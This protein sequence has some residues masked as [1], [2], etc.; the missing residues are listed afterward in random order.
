M[1]GEDTGAGGPSPH[2]YYQAVLDR[3]AEL[4]RPYFHQ[5]TAEEARAQL[6]AG[7]AGAPPPRGLPPL[8]AVEDASIA[9]PGGPIPLRRYRP[10]GEVL[11]AC[12]YLHAGGWI[13]GDLD[14]SDATCRRL[15]AAASCEIVSVDYR[16]APEHPYPA[17]LD[18]AFAVLNWV[19]GWA[20]GPLLLAGE[21][22]G[23]NLAAACA[24][25]ARDDGGPAVAGQ[26]LAYPVT[27]PGLDTASHRELG[28]RN[29]LLS[30][31]DMRCFWDH[32]CPP[33]VDRSDPKVA[34]LR[35]AQASGLPP[36]LVF[37]ADLDPLRDEG[38]AYAARLR[39]AGVPVRTRRDPG[40]LHGYLGAAGEIPLAA[41]AVA[42]AGE[43]MRGLLA[44]K[45]RGR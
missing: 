45:G 14:F 8:A 32:Y 24:I 7:S 31:A 28:H 22:S 10:Q 21:S 1:S 29:W 34:P 15:A 17:A 40:M 26:F 36:A 4:G 20:K 35:I 23:G 33:G 2:P 38:L 3:Y 19:H 9:G 5:I 16:L 30:S 18:D 39:E 25:R 13:M 43:W 42:E 11:G 37:V 27:D 41:E 12:V 44:A 6:K